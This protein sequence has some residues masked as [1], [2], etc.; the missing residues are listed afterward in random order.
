MRGTFSSQPNLLV[1]VLC[2]KGKSGFHNRSSSVFLLQSL[3][4]PL[5]S[6]EFIWDNNPFE[7]KNE[8]PLAHKVRGRPHVS[9]KLISLC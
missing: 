3:R 9:C 6:N 5:I 8:T 2:S 7:D 4:G 1:F